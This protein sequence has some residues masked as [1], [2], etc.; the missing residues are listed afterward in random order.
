MTSISLPKIGLLTNFSNRVFSMFYILSIS[1]A[2]KQLIQLEK[3]LI[4]QQEKH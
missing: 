3:P 2:Q 4:F 1:D